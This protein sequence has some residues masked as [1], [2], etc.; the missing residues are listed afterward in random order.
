MMNLLTIDWDYFL[1]VPHDDAVKWIT[2]YDWGT[3]EQQN[4]LLTDMLW[5]TRAAQFAINDMPLP[6]CEGWEDFA[7]RFT[8]SEDATLLYSNSHLF[9]ALDHYGD[10]WRPDE[11]GQVWLYDAHHDSGYKDKADLERITCEDWLGYYTRGGVQTHVRY[12]KWHT[13]W[14]D[15]DCTPATPPSSRALDSGNP[16]KVNGKVVT[17]DVVQICRS[18]AWV[19]PWC[20][21]DFMTFLGTWG[22]E[23]WYGPDETF[24]EHR[25]FS[26]EQVEADVKMRRELIE[27]AQRG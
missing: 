15:V 2:F 22:I 17:F 20:D 6:R 25:P 27:R 1:P 18:D 23:E 19:P 4:P 11:F 3:T 10:L 8:L 21:D 7:Q 9:A 5:Q 26:A 24:R 12:P 13:G 16:P 14:K